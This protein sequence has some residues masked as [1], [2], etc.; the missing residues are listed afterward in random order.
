VEDI[1]ARQAN[2]KCIQS[3]VVAAVTH[4][5]AP[6]L[7][8]VIL[9]FVVP[10]FAGVLSGMSDGQARLPLPTQIMLNAAW[11]FVK[12]WYVYLVLLCGALVMDATVHYLLACHLNKVSARIWYLLILLVEGAVSL[13]FIIALL[14]PVYRMAT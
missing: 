9:L 13:L 12:Y 2:V 10:R 8:F 7:W 11:L 14:L 4:A 3:A 6:A 1:S 5:V